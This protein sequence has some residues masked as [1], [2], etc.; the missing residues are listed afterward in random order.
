M[1]YRL[2]ILFASIF[3]TLIVFVANAQ[4]QAI[5]NC[6]DGDMPCFDRRIDEY[7]QKITELQGQQKTLSSTIKY[8][9]AKTYLTEG[10]IRRTQLEILAL[11][12]E[13]E[14]LSNR[15]GGLEVSLKRLS[16]ILISRIQEGY[17]RRADEPV[18][19]FFSSQG[20]GD[21]VTKLKYMQLVQSYT[22]S[23]IQDAEEQKVSYDNEKTVKEKKQSEV[24]A[25]RRKLEAQRKTLQQQKEQ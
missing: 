15:I 24:E 8:L 5:E 20:F 12:K 22:Q 18:L 2:Q 23:M 7:K 6:S 14:V 3:I 11:E 21:F 1:R 4:V 25:L 17:K 10:E 16:E 9:E 13:I 19:L